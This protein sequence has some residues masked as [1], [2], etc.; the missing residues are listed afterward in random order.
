MKGE[1]RETWEHLKK[2]VLDRLIACQ[3]E[4]CVVVEDGEFPEIFVPL[5]SA[6][7]FGALGQPGFQEIVHE[8]MEY[9][10]MLGYKMILHTSYKGGPALSQLV[11]IKTE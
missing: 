3:D 5:D 11:A 2:I 9:L 10:R 8:L 4:D 6:S 1:Q 7:S